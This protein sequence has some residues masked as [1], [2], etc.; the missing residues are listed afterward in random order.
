MLKAD[1]LQRW[2]V[3]LSNECPLARYLIVLPVKVPARMADPCG[4]PGLPLRRLVG[5]VVPI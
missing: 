1:V 4:Y 3:L 5:A 2:Q